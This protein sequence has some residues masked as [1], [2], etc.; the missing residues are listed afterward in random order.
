MGNVERGEQSTL[1]FGRLIEQRSGYMADN[2][3]GES[4]NGTAPRRSVVTIHDVARHAGVSS[5]TV[6][7][8]MNG[9]RYVSETMRRKNRSVTGSN[10]LRYSL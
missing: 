2:E 6:S 5:M 10:S 3:D 4:E 7:R 8:V 1:Q 9:K